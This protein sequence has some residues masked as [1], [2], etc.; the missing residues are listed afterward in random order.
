MKMKMFLVVL[1]CGLGQLIW[2]GNA[3]GASKPVARQFDGSVQVV[4]FET[5]RSARHLDDPGD[6]VNFDSTL[7]LAGRY[8][9]RFQADVTE[10]NAGNGANGINESPDDPDDGGWDWVLNWTTDPH[11][12]S[13]AASPTNLYG[14]TALGA[15]HAYIKQGNDSLWTLLLDAA[16]V[17]VDAGP[18]SIRSASDMKFLM[19]FDDLYDIEVGPTS[20]YADAARAKYDGRITAYGSALALAQT[21]RDIRGTTHGYPNGI[22]GWDVGAFA[23][24]AQMLFER[25]GGTYDQDADDI[26]E[27]LYQDSFADNPGYFD[28]VDDAGWDPNYANVNYWWYTLGITGLL[29]AFSASGS[30]SA[31]IPGLTQ[32]LLDS[33]YSDGAFSYCYGA[34]VDDQDWQ[35]TAYTVGSLD[36]HDPIAF[37]TEI[38]NGTYWTAATQDA[39]GGWLYSGEDHYPEIGGENTAALSLGS[40]AD[41][42]YVSQTWLSQADVDV[43]NQSNAAKLV[44]GYSAFNTIGGALQG[45]TSRTVYVLA[46]VYLTQVHPKKFT[47]LSLIGAGVGNTI[48]R[49]PN[50]TMPDIYFAGGPSRPVLFIDSCTAHVSNLTVDG[51]GRG[52]NNSR[53]IG[54][55]FWNSSGSL[56]DVE[57]LNVRD[58]PLSSFSQ[59]V[60]ISI[61]RNNGASHEVDLTNVYIEGFQKNGTSFTGLGTIVN[62]DNVTVVGLGPSSTIVQN[63]IQYGSG[64]TGEI[65]NSLVSGIVWAGSSFIASSILL[66]ESNHVDIDESIVTNCQAG[67]YNLDSD[68]SVNRSE[69]TATPSAINAGKFGVRLYSGAA[70]LASL[71]DQPDAY[72]EAAMIDIRDRSRS[73]DEDESVTLNETV[74]TGAASAGSYGILVNVEGDS[75]AI[76]IT[77]CDITNWNRGID[78]NALYSGKIFP[79]VIANNTLTNSTNAF[80]NTSNHFWDSNCYSDYASNFGYPGTYEISGAPQWN[81]DQNPN[82]NGCYDVNLLFEEEFVGC[83]GSD[84]DTAYLCITLA[85]VSVPNL[86]LTIQLPAGFAAGVPLSGG[87]VTPWM[88]AD[89]NLIQAF[90]IN[91]PNDRIQVDAGFQNPGSTGDLNNYVALIPVVNI[92][93]GTG[94]HLIAGTSSLW[95]DILG[96]E[97]TNEFGLGTS[98]IRVDCAPPSISAFT[99]LAT[100]AFGSASQTANRLSATFTD[101]LSDLDS[102]WV[103]FAPSG[104]TYT[105]YSG[106]L[107]SPQTL[108]FPSLSDTA[109]FYAQL[110]NNACNTLT[111]HLRDSECNIATPINIANVGRDETPPSLVVA[112]SIPANFCFNNTPATANYGGAWL[113]NYLNITSLRGNLPCSAITGSLI[114]SHTGVADFVV[115]LDKTNYPVNDTEALALWTWMLGIPGFSTSDGGAFTINVKTLDCSGSES[116]SQQ[117]AICVDTQPPQNSFT[118][119]D[120]RPAHLGV[121]LY[122][123][124]QASADAQEM[125]IYRSPMSNEYPEFANGL[126]NDPGNYNVSNI[127]PTGWTL[128]MTQSGITGAITSGQSYGSPNNRGDSYSHVVGADTFWLDAQTGWSDGVSNSALF[129]DI[130]RYVTFV[131][132]AGG[133]WSIGDTVEILENADRSTNYWLGDFSTADSPGDSLSRGRVDTDDLGLMSAVY[134]TNAGG[135]RDIGPV[136]VE[137]GNV[138]KGIPNPDAS[139]TIDFDDLTPFSF[140]FHSV[141][142]IGIS[143]TEFAVRPDPTRQRPFAL[144][145]ESPGVSF[146]L[147]SDTRLLSGSLIAVTMSLT[148]NESHIVK[149]VEAELSYDHTVLDVVQVI[150][151]NAVSQDGTVFKKAAL[152]SGCAGKVGMVAASCGGV[153]TLEGNT[154]LG[155]VTFRVKATAADDCELALSSVKLLDNTGTILEIEGEQMTLLASSAVPADFALHQNFPNPFNSSTLIEYDLPMASDVQLIIYNTT[156]QV[157]A[158]ILDNQRPAGYHQVP[159]DAANV[160]SGVYIYRLKAGPFTQSKKMILLR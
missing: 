157:V 159:W 8:L 95:I 14:V 61:N 97:H 102:I 144:L 25:Y 69:I 90:A 83:A 2:S 140:N 109:Q 38:R 153:S 125:R 26:A 44:W 96:G 121:W 19:L 33:Q 23:V 42:V 107:T 32:R 146:V 149:A 106:S 56:T 76:S 136:V 89:S 101:A 77:N 92:S 138:G 130:Y 154:I 12:H 112:T 142:P 71:P 10:D 115:S 127:P 84:C 45:V 55:A 72:D 35:S 85:D 87:I 47:H 59:G 131:K 60:G 29:D 7:Y 9:Q 116:A 21:I 18:S 6:Y 3:L 145:D 13:V 141:S 27:V 117:F 24:V 53:M 123:S 34:N 108:T 152:K 147:S 70:A 113:D 139:G 67:I 1:C 118:A 57:I 134:F 73:L 64:A 22:I 137:N 31:E 36:A 160:A 150:D 135:Y 128:V 51:N 156:G 81:I 63:G 94:T 122:W 132:D 126:W 148:G 11:A 54:V 104:G 5:M 41:T 88:N 120:A 28:V 20:V 4:H 151:G 99:N 40:P 66:F 158:T 114:L 74:I 15:Y 79:A 93:A 155:T 75:L 82:P 39:G 129:R 46:G 103:T 65:H 52:N 37:K 143:E 119:F 91:L 50:T 43:Y 62:C 105:V 80:D 30:H 124:W 133:N 86:Q 111:L 68:C 48:I 49:A 100:C 58:T 78:L 110:A 17:M 98:A 16:T